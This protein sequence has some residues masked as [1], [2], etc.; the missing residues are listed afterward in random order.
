[1]R[2]NG[3]AL[4]DRLDWLVGSYYGH[5]KID[6]MDSRG[7]G[8]DAER[9]INCISVAGSAALAPTLNTNSPTCSNAPTTAWPGFQGYAALLGANRL[10]NTGALANVFHQTTENYAFFTHNVFQII[11]DRVSLTLGAR[12]THETKDVSSVVNA[13]N[14]LCPKILNSA[15]QS[16][17]RVPCFVNSSAPN[18]TAGAPGTQLSDGQWTGVA[19]LTVKPTRDLMMY[20][21]Y[22]KGYK[23]AGFNL[24]VSGFDLP[25]TTTAGTAAQNAACTALLAKPANTINNGRA[26]AT[27][28]QYGAEKVT[29]YELGVK[30]RRPGFDLTAALFYQAFDN[31]Q[32]SSFNGVSFEVLSLNGCKDDL[33][34]GPIDNNNTTGVCPTSRLKPGVVS[35]GFEIEAGLQPVT[36]LRFNFGLTYLDAR[37]DKNLVGTG[38]RALTTQLF[39]L[40]GERTNGSEYTLTGTMSWTPSISDKVKG[41][42]YLDYRFQSANGSLTGDLD[43]EKK[44]P[45]Y[46]VVNGRLGLTSADRRWAIELWGTNLLNQKYWIAGADAPLLGSGTYRSVAS[47]AAL[48]FPATANQISVVFPGEP[49]MYGVTVKTRF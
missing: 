44:M 23:S 5:E 3:K 33:G 43:L 45:A 1:M 7:F 39:Q 8:N 12:Y 25:C 10:N 22:S 20:A 11:P 26:E 40:P 21:T 27:D 49:R 42:F 31:F 6:T 36:D 14:D 16:L 24:D 41:L 4:G 32:F 17:A 18:L 2:L 29:S 28:L 46:G 47:P 35:K 34:T 37:Y 15:Y 30:W 48:G 38:G 9:V 19:T 13:T